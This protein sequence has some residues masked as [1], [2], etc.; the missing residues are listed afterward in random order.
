MTFKYVL[1]SEEFVVIKLIAYIRFCPAIGTSTW[2]WIPMISRTQELKFYVLCIRKHEGNGLLGHCVESCTI[3]TIN[4]T[5]LSGSSNP[6]WS[7]LCIDK[8]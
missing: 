5:R 2:K 3:C 1:A 8:I 6:S 7:R 4:Q